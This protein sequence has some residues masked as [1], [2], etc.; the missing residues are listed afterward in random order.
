MSQFYLTLPSNSYLANQSGSEGQQINEP[1]AQ[2]LSKFRVQLPHKI[3]L[4]GDWEVALSEI[5]YPNSWFN[6]N[7]GDGLVRIIY[8]D[9]AETEITCEIF[10]NKYSTPEQ[11][12][13]ALNFN[14]DT[15]LAEHE[16]QGGVQPQDITD[17]KVS[18]TYQKD[19]K[20]VVVKVAEPRIVQE[21]YMS[22]LLSYMLGFEE[23]VVFVKPSGVI[24]SA[25]MAEYPV[26]LKAGFYA[27]YVYCDLVEN[28]VVGNSLV[29]LLRTVTI[30]GQHE[31][32]MCTIYN[33]PHYL[34][35]ARK[36]F[37]SIEIS[38]N[39]DQ[40][41]PVKFQFGKVIVKLAFRK[42]KPGRY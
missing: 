1:V 25:I 19:L 23:A 33:T 16:W 27:M 32:V 29:P 15:T 39:D 40:N 7:K 2:L 5:M 30:E 10:P 24:K 34:P 12:V 18:F 4:E 42:Q 3:R 8:K 11:L 17:Y 36:E 22:P 6:I 41:K 9:T 35:L 26:D 21:F 38:I 28:Q 20:R 37:D 14:I 13:Q 31:E